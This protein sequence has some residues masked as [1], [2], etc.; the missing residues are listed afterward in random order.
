MALAIE[1]FSLA[2][3]SHPED[4][5]LRCKR[6]QAHKGL[7][8][9]SAADEDFTVAIALLSNTYPAVHYQRG[10][11]RL[12]QNRYEEAVADFTIAIDKQA[13]APA[14]MYFSRS[15]ALAQILRYE[16]ALNDVQTALKNDPLDPEKKELEARL[17][18]HLPGRYSLPVPTAELSEDMM[19]LRQLVSMTSA[20]GSKPNPSFRLPPIPAAPPAP[21]EEERQLTLAV[22]RAERMAA[23]RKRLAA[24]EEAGGAT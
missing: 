20:L 9:L 1:S 15:Q 12:L 23:L 22:E 4:G 6:G 17:L 16:P 19:L 5:W 14:Y 7:M 13:D 24:A 10:H 21:D 2:I 8:Q 11:C 18:A 3:A